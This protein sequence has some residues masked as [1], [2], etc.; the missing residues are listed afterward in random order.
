MADISHIG[1]MVAAGV[2]RNPLVHGFDIV[3]TTSHKTLRGPRGGL[4]LCRKHLSKAIDISEFPYLHGGP[5]MN[6]VA[7]AAIT[8]KKAAT[9]GGHVAEETLDRVGIT[10]N[11]QVPDIG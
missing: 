8:F 5:H 3:T 7:D 11:K 2:K 10:T 6:N 9:A 1:G 4:I